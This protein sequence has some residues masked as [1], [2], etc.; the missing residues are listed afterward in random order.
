MK[1]KSVDEV[2]AAMKRNRLSIIH[3][4]KGVVRAN[5]RGFTHVHLPLRLLRVLDFPVLDRS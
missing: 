5:R 3:Q 1:I 2:N 4:M